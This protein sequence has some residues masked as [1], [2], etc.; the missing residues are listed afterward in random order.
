M[1]PNSIERTTPI[2]GYNPYAFIMGEKS[3]YSGRTGA[4]MQGGTL[5]Y[6]AK[7]PENM[8]SNGEKAKKGFRITPMLKGIIGLGAVALGG[9]GL[10]KCGGKLK[11]VKVS[12]EEGLFNKIFGGVSKGKDSVIN[13]SKKFGGFISGKFHAAGAWIRGKFHKP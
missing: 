2:L 8:Y 11:N 6:F 10:V 3:N 4:S 13:G 9:I 7:K 12:N 1:L 5:D